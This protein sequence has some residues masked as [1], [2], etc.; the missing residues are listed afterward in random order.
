MRPHGYWIDEIDW[1]WH[2]GIAERAREQWAQ[3]LLPET[4]VQP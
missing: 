1:P 3:P 4:E 2:S